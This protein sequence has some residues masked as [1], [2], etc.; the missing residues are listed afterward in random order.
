MAANEYPS[1]TAKVQINTEAA[2]KVKYVDV[3]VSTE[4]VFQVEHLSTGAVRVYV[5]HLGSVEVGKR[6]KKDGNELTVKAGVAGQLEDVYTFEPDNTGDITQAI[7]T[8]IRIE[9]E[10]AEHS[11]LDTI[12]FKGPN[13]NPK[14]PIGDLMER[15]ESSSNREATMAGDFTASAG[16]ANEATASHLVQLSGELEMSGSVL[17]YKTDRLNADGTPGLD[18]QSDEN[19]VR[20]SGTMMLNERTARRGH[21][22]TFDQ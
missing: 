1:N 5:S 8:A 19:G 6:F 3:F 21:D 9:K 17:W 4:H 18:G 22:E 13:F 12:L 7:E 14:N 15:L 2:A 10:N 11:F 16:F 20:L